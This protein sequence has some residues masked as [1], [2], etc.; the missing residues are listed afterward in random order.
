[1]PPVAARVGWDVDWISPDF[2]REIVLG[3]YFEGTFG[4]RSAIGGVGGGVGVGV[5][6]ELQFPLN[7]TASGSYLVPSNGS[8][9]LLWDAF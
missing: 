1:M 4:S 2:L 9:D 3:A 7:F 5:T 8:V 6:M